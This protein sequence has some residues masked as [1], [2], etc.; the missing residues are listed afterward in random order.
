M[1]Q[2]ATQVLRRASSGYSQRRYYRISKNK[3]LRN[4]LKLFG[5][6]KEKKIDSKEINLLN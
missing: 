2:T 6:L 4:N 3:E 1:A 5:I